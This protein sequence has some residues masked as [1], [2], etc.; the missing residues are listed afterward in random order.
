M[1]RNLRAK[2]L[3]DEKFNTE[4]TGTAA[5]GITKPQSTEAN[6]TSLLSLYQFRSPSAEA[7]EV[8]CGCAPGFADLNLNELEDFV[9]LAH[10]RARVLQRQHN[11]VGSLNERNVKPAWLD[12]LDKVLHAV[13]GVSDRHK[14]ERNPRAHLTS[15]HA[16]MVDQLSKIRDSYKQ[17]F[18]ATIFT[19]ELRVL[20]HNLK[21]WKHES[22]S[23]LVSAMEHVK[24]LGANEEKQRNL[25]F[26][27]VHQRLNA[28]ETQTASG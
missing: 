6:A 21:E 9:R 27:H 23:A 15:V 10:Y 11:P 24:E 3:V 16:R 26:F 1:C 4:E 8:S 2:T 28:K 13:Y 17:K 7:F 14:H 22:V 18:G 20:I 5:L 12:Q 25:E 19:R